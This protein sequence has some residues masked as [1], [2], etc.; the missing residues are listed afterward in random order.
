MCPLGII[1][2]LCIRA[3]CIR[4]VTGK[5]RRCLEI[6]R[7]VTVHRVGGVCG[8]RREGVAPSR[9]NER[10]GGARR[11]AGGKRLARV[12]GI[13]SCCGTIVAG[14]G[15]G[16]GRSAR[17]NAPSLV[18]V[19]RL[20]VEDSTKMRL[21]TRISGLRFNRYRSIVYVHIYII[22]A[23]VG[24]GHGSS[25]GQNAPPSIRVPRLRVKD[26]THIS[27]FVFNGFRHIVYVHIYIN[28]AVSPEERPSV[29]PRPSPASRRQHQD[30]IIYTYT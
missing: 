28:M 9:M 8:V 10:R 1:N 26:I 30:A 17:Q 21:Y 23:R 20:R 6:R 13:R 5:E 11:P 19:P 14:V 24:C 16:H 2:R 15:C 22:V 12:G 7:G 4:F 3:R 25:A 29:R 18:S 27:R